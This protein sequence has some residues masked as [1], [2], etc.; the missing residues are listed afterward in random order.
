[1]LSYKMTTHI[2]NREC[3]EDSAVCLERGGDYCFVVADGLGGHGKGE[4][5]SR[6]LVEVFAREFEAADAADTETFLRT[7]FDAAQAEIM[8]EQRASGARFDMKTT[9]VALVVIG[10]KCRFGHIGDSRLYMF[11]RNKVKTRTLD[12]SVSQMLVMARELREKDIAK[13]PDRNRL[14]RVV[15]VEWDSP[16]YDLSDEYALAD[17]Q[18]FLLCTDGF[19][20]LITDKQMS[21]FLKKSAAADDWLGQ[22]TA[23]VEKNG[24]GQ[25]MDNYT[26]IAIRRE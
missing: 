14:L 7:A 20:E 25:D 16:K 11:S 19:W 23:E 2:G 22:M 15:G 13:H 8:A 4:V 17:C 24:N 12:H 5:A 9:A 10:E 1:M 3:N 6:K 26:A 18:A 21:A